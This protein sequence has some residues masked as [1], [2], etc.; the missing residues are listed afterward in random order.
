M[1][2]LVQTSQ[3]CCQSHKSAAHAVLCGTRCL[4]VTINDC[5]VVCVFNMPEFFIVTL[6]CTFPTYNKKVC[7]KTVCGITPRPSRHIYCV[8]WLCHLLLCLI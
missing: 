2:L 1:A 4:V 8:C 6:Q 7:C 3:L 5:V